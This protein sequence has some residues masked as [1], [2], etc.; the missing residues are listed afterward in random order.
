MVNKGLPQGSTLI[1]LPMSANEVKK[2]RM[3][4]FIEDIMLYYH[5][6]RI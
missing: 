6:P 4:V 1:P 5:L 3:T 2:S